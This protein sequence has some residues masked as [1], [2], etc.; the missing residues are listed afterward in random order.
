M[1][2]PAPK[3]TSPLPPPGLLLPEGGA[4]PFA[5]AGAGAAALD[6]P[7]LLAG[8][9]EAAA[10]PVAAAVPAVA[11]AVAGASPALDPINAPTLPLSAIFRLFL[12]FGLTAFGGPVAQI[13]RL[14]QALV[15]EQKWISVARFNRVVSVYQALP[16]PEATV[17][18]GRAASL[19]VTLVAKLPPPLLPRSRCR[20]ASH[21]CAQ[22]RYRLL[23]LAAAAAGTA[24]CRS[25]AAT[26][27]CWRAAV[28]APSW[29]AW[30]FCCP[31]LC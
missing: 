3:M 18:G 10:V 28:P 25:S 24:A 13:E 23:P 15:V 27:A 20:A 16:G 7:A 26:L 17:S 21:S 2:D 29:R 12:G 8:G 30:P 19:L 5:V 9:D 22:P 6:T 14:K 31:A 4:A 1:S 11:G